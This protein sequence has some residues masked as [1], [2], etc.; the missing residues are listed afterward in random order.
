MSSL[1]RHPSKRE[2][3]QSFERAAATYD[4]AARVQRWVCSRL[5][6]GLPASLI[7]AVILDAGCGTGFAL[8]MLALRFPAARLIA[9]DF[10]EG[11][12]EQIRQPVFRLLGDVERLPLQN[13]MAGLYWSSLTLQWCRPEVL[14]KEACRVLWPNGTLALSSLLPGTFL[15]IEEAFADIDAY[16]HVLEFT[17]AEGVRAALAHAGFTDI[18]TQVETGVA[19][20]K[21]VKSLLAAI[22]AIGA[23]RIGTGSRKTLMG[24]AAWHKLVENL[25][26]RR[27]PRG[28]PLTYQVLLCYARKPGGED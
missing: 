23:T 25:E 21:D 3:R 14:A 12:L 8:Q 6:A 4:S 9:L 24:K 15:E 2:I 20:Y 13:E 22:R 27:N 28:I 17:P 18:D 19:H 11:M 16:R 26:S 7:P 5:V 1:R 10:S